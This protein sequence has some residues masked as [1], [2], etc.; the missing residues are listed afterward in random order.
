LRNEIKLRVDD[1]SFSIQIYRCIIFT[2]RWWWRVLFF[3]LD[4]LTIVTRLI[5]T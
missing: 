3:L 4:L 5:M 2:W 1:R